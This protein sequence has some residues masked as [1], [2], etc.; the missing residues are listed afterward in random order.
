MISGTFPREVERN[1]IRQI[2]VKYTNTD[3]L[4][5][6][7]LLIDAWLQNVNYNFGIISYEYLYAAVDRCGC[8]S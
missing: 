5:I 8:T 4:V 6:F 2:I 7:D 3:A 1:D